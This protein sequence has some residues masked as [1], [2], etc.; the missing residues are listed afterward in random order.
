MVVLKAK[1]NGN[2][3]YCRNNRQGFAATKP[4]LLPLSEEQTLRS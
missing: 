4:T 2:Q 1:G 3:D